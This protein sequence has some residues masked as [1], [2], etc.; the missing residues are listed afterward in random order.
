MVS[1]WCL[2][3]VLVFVSW[4]CLLVVSLGGV[5]VVSRSDLGGALVVSVVPLWSLNGVGGPLLFVWW[6]LSCVSVLFWWC[7]CGVLVVSP[8]LGS[9]SASS[10]WCVHGALVVSQRFPCRYE[11]F[12]VS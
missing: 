11:V 1:R 12:T 3:G 6:C 7:F 8:G 2:S 9:L 4:W 10:G 5:S